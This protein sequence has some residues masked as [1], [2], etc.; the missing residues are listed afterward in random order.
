MVLLFEEWTKN[1]APTLADDPSYLITNDV[2]LLE[3]GE[4]DYFA[5]IALPGLFI[6]HLDVLMT[7]A[8]LVIKQRVWKIYQLKSAPYV[9]QH[10]LRWSIDSCERWNCR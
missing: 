5:L 1:T 9:L 7:L 10:K 4:A 2:G 3:K 6:E 8:E